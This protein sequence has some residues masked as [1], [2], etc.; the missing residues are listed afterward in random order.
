MA[1]RSKWH[2]S[3]STFLS[4]LVMA[5]SSCTPAPPADQ[6]L[7][8]VQID[9]VIIGVP[10][11]Q[12]GMDRL[13]EMTGVRPVFGGEHPGR[14]TRNALL[15][16]GPGVY[17]EL[18][19][20]QEGAELPED[21][22]GLLTLGEPTPWGWAASSQDIEA[23]MARLADL[24]YETFEP[25]AG[26]RATPDGGMLR[27]VS[28]GVESPTIPEIPFFI[29]WAPDSPHPSTTSPDGCTLSS[30]TVFTPESEEVSRFVDALGLD[31]SVEAGG[32]SVG[33]YGIGEYEIALDCPAGRVV[34]R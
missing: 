2:L 8:Q 24:G 29:E 27:W 16:L 22:A 11:L 4:I 7:P 1:Q 28:G 9:H 18:L 25:Q 19:A 5:F 6:E 32:G 23:T 34:F 12:G 30:M 20:P 15:S 21:A 33:Q 13:E 17:L 14:G 10:D 31:V 3:G 26:S